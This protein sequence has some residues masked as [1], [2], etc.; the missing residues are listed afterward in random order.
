MDACPPFRAIVYALLLA[1]YDRSVR[2]RHTGE[3][4]R[5]GRLDLFM[6]VYLPYC[7]RFITAEIYG[8]QERCLR[9]V[10]RAAGLHT[11][12]GSYDDFCNGMLVTV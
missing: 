2:E 1:W 8:E 7:D 5:A 10:A 3:K 4:F 9:E 11:V 6:A 12:V